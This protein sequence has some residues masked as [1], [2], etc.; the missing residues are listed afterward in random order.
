MDMPIRSKPNNDLDGF[1]L[2]NAAKPDSRFK[3]IDIRLARLR[4]GQFDESSPVTET[5]SSVVFTLDLQAGETEI[6]T[7]FNTADGKTLGAYYLDVR[8]IN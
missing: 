6:E 5:M 4:V 8:R 1:K 2:F 3:A 7:W